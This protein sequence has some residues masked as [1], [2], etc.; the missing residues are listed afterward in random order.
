MLRPVKGYT[1]L[2]RP[3]KTVHR[4]KSAEMR[5]TVGLIIVPD[6]L[7]VEMKGLFTRA[8]CGSCAVFWYGYD[9]C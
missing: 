8:S 5:W 4:P 2:R 1:S 6:R 7:D 3:L 9:G